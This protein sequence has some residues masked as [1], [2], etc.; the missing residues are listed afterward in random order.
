MTNLLPNLPD[1]RDIVRQLHEMVDY[2]LFES[3][4]WPADK[5]SRIGFWRIV[6][7]M[8]LQE[9]VPGTDDTTRYTALGLDCGL[10]LATYF[11]GAHEPMEIPELLQCLGLIDE[12]DA[13]AV[14]SLPEGQILEYVEKLVRR[15][16]FRAFGQS[17][18][19]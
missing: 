6:E 5:E 10:P 18:F 4:I 8:G 2:H 16:Y 11:I 12:E 3:T 17:I 1:R 19:H 13:E 9:R 15:A 14:H 7:Q